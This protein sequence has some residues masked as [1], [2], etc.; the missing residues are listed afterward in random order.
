MTGRLDPGRWHLLDHWLARTARSAR[1][2]ARGAARRTLHGRSRTARGIARV[3]GERRCGESARCAGRI[4][5]VRGR[6]RKHSQASDPAIASA[7]GSCCG[8]SASAACPKCSSPN[9]SSPARISRAA[10]KLMAS[11]SRQRGLARALQS[12]AA[13]PRRAQRQP[14]RAFLRQRHRDGRPAVAR[15]GVRR[16][17]SDRSPLHCAAAGR[18]R[19]SCAVPADRRSGR[20]RASAPGR[21]S[22]HQTEQR[23]GHARRRGQAARLRHRQAARRRSRASRRRDAHAF[24]DA[25]LCK[26]GADP[27]RS[28]HDRDRRVSARRVVVLP[29]RRRAAVSDGRRRRRR[30]R[31]G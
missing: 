17:R 7:I 20:A 10:L 11:G 2:R 21:A 9:A 19:A 15:D 26:P 27:R 14:H 8:A 18:R 23:A 31:S 6:R 22:R 25:R 3:A 5:A 29:A 30:N 16:G 13:H 24:P 28:D 4:G 1:A 12:R